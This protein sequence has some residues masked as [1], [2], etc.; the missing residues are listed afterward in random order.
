M[1]LRIIEYPD[2]DYPL[3]REQRDKRFNSYAAMA[4]WA[5]RDLPH[6]WYMVR[7]HNDRQL[8]RVIKHEPGRFWVENKGNI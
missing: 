7:A 1:A 3:T 5:N 8:P 2:T 6:G 4:D